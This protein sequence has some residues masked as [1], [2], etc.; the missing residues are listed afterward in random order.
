VVRRNGATTAELESVY[1][2]G[3]EGFVRVATVITRDPEVA[4]DAV[5]SAFVAAVRQR[6]SYRGVG[7]LEGWVWQI[8]VNEARRAA[9]GKKTVPLDEVAEPVSVNGDGV[10]DESGVRRWVGA[11]PQRQREAVFL[12]YFADLDYKTIAR[13]LD[14]EPGTVSATLSAAHQTLRKRLEAMQR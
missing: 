9:R 14:L 8:V 13:V 6:R 10:G 7:S 4:H 5:Q 12:R 2:G 11:L 3:F 1:R